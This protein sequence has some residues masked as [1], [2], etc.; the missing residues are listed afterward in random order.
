MR[1]QTTRFPPSPTHAF[2]CYRNIA[3]PFV[4]CI[5]F[6]CVFRDQRSST[7]ALR[8]SVE[9]VRGAVTAHSCRPAIRRAA[10]P[11]VSAMIRT[12]A[13]LASTLALA[14]AAKHYSVGSQQLVGSLQDYE[15]DGLCDDTVKSLS[16]ARPSEVSE[17][18]G[19]SI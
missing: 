2:H 13:L 5:I 18:P 14:S 6:F 10:I 17:I 8:Q 1:Q 12:V 11:F 9:V 19:H 7:T 16:G 4:T 15:V 3:A